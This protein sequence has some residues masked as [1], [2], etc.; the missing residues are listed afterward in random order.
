M[1]R[2]PVMM[3]QYSRN[4]GRPSLCGVAT[5]AE[6][7]SLLAAHDLPTD[8][9]DELIDGMPGTLLLDEAAEVLAADLALCYPRLETA[10]VRV[11]LRPVGGED[12]RRVTVVTHDRPGLLA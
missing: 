9:V 8:L 5:V 7:T 11:Q 2:Q 12:A 6:L 10:E 1:L 3:R 4:T